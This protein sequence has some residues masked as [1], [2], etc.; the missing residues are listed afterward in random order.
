MIAKTISETSFGSPSIL[1]PTERDA[2]RM[3]A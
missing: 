1:T 3:C 2:Y